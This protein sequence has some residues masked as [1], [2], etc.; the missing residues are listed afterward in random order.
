MTQNIAR[1]G[2][3]IEKDVGPAKYGDMHQIRQLKNNLRTLDPNAP[4]DQLSI[5]GINRDIAELREK[6]GMSADGSDDLPW[7]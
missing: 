2:K 4:G 7:S 5:N 1:L 3:Q 6:N